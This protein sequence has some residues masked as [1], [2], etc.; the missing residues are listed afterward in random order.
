MLVSVEEIQIGQ[1]YT[2]GKGI[3]SGKV[4]RVGHIT[5]HQ[6]FGKLGRR[7]MV[8]PSGVQFVD[9]RRRDESWPDS[10]TMSS[11]DVEGRA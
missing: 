5:M 1:R 4:S 7:R 3:W 9:V 10:V 8:Y 11:T 2:W 6:Q